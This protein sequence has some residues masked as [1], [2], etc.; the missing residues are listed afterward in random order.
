MGAA[1]YFKE[2]LLDD[3]SELRELHAREAELIMPMALVRDLLADISLLDFQSGEQDD[4]L[5]DEINSHLGYL[6]KIEE[7]A[8]AQERGLA[9]SDAQ[10]SEMQKELRKLGESSTVSKNRE[11]MDQLIKRLY[12]F[13]GRLSQELDDAHRR[14]EIT[15]QEYRQKSN[16]YAL[17]ILSIGLFGFALAAIVVAVFFSRL[18]RT[19]RVLQRRT[20]KLMAGE[21]GPSLALDRHDEV[22]DLSESIDDMALSL[23]KHEQ[24][25]AGINQRLGQ[26]EKIFAIGTFAAGIAHEIGN[27]IQA[28]LALS[29]EVSDKLTENIS[30]ENVREAIP[31]VERIGH[32]AER[33]SAAIR[34]LSE[35]G[36]P[37]TMEMEVV[38]IN[39]VV[40]QT[41][42]LLRFDPRF[43]R[44]SLNLELSDKQLPV[45]GV[46]DQLSQVIINAL[47][48]AADATA[49]HGG[50]VWVTTHSDR[51]HA[52]ITVR[53]D[54]V[55]MLPETL[56]RATET[57]FTTKP[58]GK[59]TGLGLA[60]CKTIVEEH[61]GKLEI[62][63]SPGHGTTFSVR[64]SIQRQELAS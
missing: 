62:E 37:A 19:L 58:R 9:P 63:S 49:E 57:F 22:G 21:Y 41:I 18:V 28:I 50:S 54:G 12:E 48:N 2:V 60:V 32:E 64:L 6:V 35:Y 11:F 45:I 43:K 61:L 24:Q 13:D 27:P 36:S 7:L 40:L 47:I 53:D 8:L 38:D 52:F 30:S 55:G 51:Q 5:I 29:A 23:E 31:R 4:E 44:I 46:A 26:Q 3:F 39:Q 25:V 10:L 34:E 42:E 59:G 17:I 14:Y 15:Y 1:L 56:S 33:L 20:K 16:T